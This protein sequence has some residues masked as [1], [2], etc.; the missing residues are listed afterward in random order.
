MRY[1]GPVVFGVMTIVATA[2]L[3]WKCQD[4]A[5]AGPAGGIL[6]ITAMPLFWLCFIGP[7]AL[8]FLVF[9]LRSLKM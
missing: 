9:F 7:C 8:L 6:I 4:L 2:L 1:L 3:W 5:K